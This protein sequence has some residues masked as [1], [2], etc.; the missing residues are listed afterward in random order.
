MKVRSQLDQRCHGGWS[1]TKMVLLVDDLPPNTTFKSAL[2]KNTQAKI[3]Y[4]LANNSYSTIAP[5][6][7]TQINQLVVGF[8]QIAANTSEQVDLVV[9]MNRNIAKTTVKNTYKV[10]YA[11]TDSQKMCYQTLHLL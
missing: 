10:S 1:N 9:S 11:V 8:P 2:V 3:L 7:V 6:D 5:S 4:K